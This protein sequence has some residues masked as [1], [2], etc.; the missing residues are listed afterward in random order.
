MRAIPSA[1][2]SA[3]ARGCFVLG[4]ELVSVGPGYFADLVVDGDRTRAAGIIVAIND[5]KWAMNG[6]AVV[7]DKAKGSAF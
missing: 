2:P 5:V 4:S 1:G 3:A 6:G 7:A